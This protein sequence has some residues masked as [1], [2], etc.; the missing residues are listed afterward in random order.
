MCD[1]DDVEIGFA[2]SVHDLV[3]KLIDVELAAW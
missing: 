3:G 1:R 2:N